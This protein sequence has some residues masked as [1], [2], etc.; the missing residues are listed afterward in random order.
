MVRKLQGR[1]AEYNVLRSRAIMQ[2]E[3]V[4]LIKS[5]LK[6]ESAI[7]INGAGVKDNKF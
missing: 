7:E 4:A 1:E 5:H 3:D 2:N 6:K